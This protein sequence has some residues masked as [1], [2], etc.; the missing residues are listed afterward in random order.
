MVWYSGFFPKNLF[1]IAL[2][3]IQMYDELKKIK[4]NKILCALSDQ[5]ETTVKT[6]RFLIFF[7]PYS[8]LS[9]STEQHLQPSI[10][11]DFHFTRAKP[12]HEV[13]SLQDA[14]ASCKRKKHLELLFNRL[15]GS[16]KWRMRFCT[17]PW[18]L[19]SCIFIPICC[20]YYFWNCFQKK[21]IFANKQKKNRI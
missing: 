21:Y 2:L 5:Q 14:R 6:E 8:L 17:S 9:S 19:P 18:A 20:I 1:F 16:K 12:E 7:F 11:C 4:G 3:K 13:Q 10:S 15:M